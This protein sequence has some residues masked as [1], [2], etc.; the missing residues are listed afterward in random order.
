MFRQDPPRDGSVVKGATSTPS[1]PSLCVQG[2]PDSS[3]PVRRPLYRTG[4]H[5]R[6]SVGL[7]HGWERKGSENKGGSVGGHSGVSGV[8]TVYSKVFPL[9]GRG[10]STTAE[11]RPVNRVRWVRSMGDRVRVETP[12][13]LFDRITN[14]SDR[15][16]GP[17]TPTGIRTVN[18]RV[19]ES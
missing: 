3:R 4:S 8:S 1:R 14:T 15:V 2:R 10:R 19:P 9:T 16:L 5:G 17:M 13:S 6:H 11:V 12:K 7:T 18:L